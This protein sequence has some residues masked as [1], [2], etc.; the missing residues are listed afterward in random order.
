M[1][2]VFS[3]DG[4]PVGISLASLFCDVIKQSATCL[5]T[6]SRKEDSGKLAVH[7]GEN[8]NDHLFYH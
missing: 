4:F 8:N 7:M 6:T 3:R 2:S 1:A 5:L